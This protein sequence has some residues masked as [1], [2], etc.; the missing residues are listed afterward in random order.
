MIHRMAYFVVL[1]F[2]V[3]LMADDG[4]AAREWLERMSL[5]IKHVNYQ[6]TLVYGGRT[7]WETLAVHH[8]VI[9]GVE[10]EKLLHLTGDPRAI[11]RHGAKNDDRNPS[12]ANPLT[13]GLIHASADLS[14]VYELSLGDQQRIAGRMAQQINIMTRD[15]YRY[16]YR[17]WLDTSTA[18]LL[19]SELLNL[20]GQTLERLQFADVEI[21]HDIPRATFEP[22]DQ[23]HFTAMPVQSLQDDEHDALQQ[24]H[25]NW[26]PRGFSVA[27]QSV[28]EDEQQRLITRMY[29]DGL[30]AFTV[31]VHFEQEPSMPSMVRQWGA[32]TAVVRY[33][34][35]EQQQV[36]IA[37]VGEIPKFTAEKIAS[38]ITRP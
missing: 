8:A 24:W 25:A 5:A 36:R 13:Q 12:P 17:L 38:S 30:A 28:R 10:H 11:I 37:V 3:P 20:E 7:H 18:L 33:Q 9:D 27:S 4:Q 22:D 31:F 2:S 29:S 16:S 35:H 21:G 34:A 14:A 6:G 32:T 19:A 23:A 15:R 26:L 1:L